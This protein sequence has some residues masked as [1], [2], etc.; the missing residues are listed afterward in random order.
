MHPICWHTQNYCLHLYNCSIVLH[1]LYLTSKGTDDNHQISHFFFFF[2]FRRIGMRILI[3]EC[4]FYIFF[5]HIYFVMLYQ[6]LRLCWLR[7]GRMILN[8]ELRGMWEKACFK[9][10]SRFAWEYI[11]KYRNFSH[12]PWQAVPLNQEHFYPCNLFNTFSL[13]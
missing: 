7:Y 1:Y 4:G 9:I 12:L 11:G 5:L 3:V 13:T 8:M 6:L 10:I 2:F